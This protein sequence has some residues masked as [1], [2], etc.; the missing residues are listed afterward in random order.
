MGYQMLDIREL[1]KSSQGLTEFINEGRETQLDEGLKDILNSLKRKF[2]QV[3]EYLFGWVAKVSSK[4]SYWL[5]V[6]DNGEI[7][8]AITPL[9]AGQAYADGEINI[10]N[11]SNAT[12]TSDGKGPRY[13]KYLRK[14]K[15]IYKYV[16][17]VNID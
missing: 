13:T 6:S 4:L 5:P 11:L 7:M 14:C 1:M 15:F 8:P 9:T 17:V 12:V 16:N 2:K 3:T 10:V